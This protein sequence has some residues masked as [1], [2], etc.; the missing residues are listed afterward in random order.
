MIAAMSANTER[1]SAGRNLLIYT[2]LVT[3]V[4][5]FTVIV[6]ND[7]AALESYRYPT[8]L[9]DGE[10]Y[11]LEANPLDPER[12][13][14][15]VEGVGYYAAEKPFRRWDR[16]VV[17]VGRDDSDR[18]FIYQM[19]SKVGA[20]DGQSGGDYFLKLGTQEYI[21]ITPIAP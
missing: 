1:A 18:Y 20:N 21:K 14:V 7:R 8:G 17:K 9:G 19:T 13:M 15:T 5:I 10:I 11:D 12:P 2:A 16:D 6:W 4:A 3:V